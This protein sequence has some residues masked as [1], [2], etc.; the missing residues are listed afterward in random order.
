MVAVG[1]HAAN[2]LESAE[3][4]EWGKE[5]ELAT[6]NAP[7]ALVGDNVDGDRICR[8]LLEE[9]AHPQS[10]GVG[11]LRRSFVHQDI[12]GAESLQS[13]CIVHGVE[14]RTDG[15]AARRERGKL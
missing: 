13:L 1:E 2:V 14:R 9:D 12:R 11:R 8:I 5:Y 15:E 4:T 7:V 3:A 10:A 6:R